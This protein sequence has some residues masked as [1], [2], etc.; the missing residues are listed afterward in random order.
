MEG[1]SSN[2]VINLSTDQLLPYIGEYG[3]FQKR[4][5]VI[6]IL[7]L[8]PIS[9]PINIIQIS[10]VNSQWRFGPNSSICCSFNGMFSAINTS[11]C[12]INRTRWKYGES[13]DIITQ[14][15]IQC[16]DEEWVISLIS[17]VL[18]VGWG[19]GAIVYG[20]GGDKYGRRIFLL[21]SAMGILLT[22]FTSTFCKN[23]HLMIVYRFIGGF[24]IPGVIIPIFLIM[25]ELV[26]KEQ[27][28]FALSLLCIAMPIG[29]C[30]ETVKAYFIHKWKVLSI[31]CTAPYLLILG[32]SKYIPES[33]EWHETHGQINEAMTIINNI[34]K[35]NKNVFPSNISL[36][37]P[38]GI[39][40]PSANPLNPLHIAEKRKMVLQS[41]A[42]SYIWFAI[43]VCS[44]RL[45]SEASKFGNTAYC[46][47][48]GIIDLPATFIVMYV[49][50][51]YSRKVITL[52]PL[53]IGSLICVFIVFIPIHVGKVKGFK[54]SRIALAIMAKLL[55]AISFNT[56]HIWSIELYPRNIRARGM[57]FVYLSFCIG[58]SAGP[59]VTVSSLSS[60]NQFIPY[61]VTGICAL[62]ACIVGMCLPETGIKTRLQ[63]NDD[64][65]T[66][67]NDIQGC[68]TEF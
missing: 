13:I 66:T 24:L 8:I 2:N 61:I 57:S 56:I 53:C 65:S 39:H 26:A 54:T 40:L 1:E 33:V 55:V 4:L 48:M 32:F 43:G 37:K 64:N 18:Y 25:S 9:Y 60:L 36:R 3:R 11:R 38:D 16:E 63:E 62:I 47:V 44:T 35:F 50:R 7:V 67:E 12:Q 21:P 41:M 58:A 28:P 10:L 31:L 52:F 20:F 5:N 17:N 27:R 30:L 23:V 19:C 22:G 45:H 42:Q 68:E 59:W 51:I 46:F 14:L 29:Y 6:F 34:A 15:N 49:S